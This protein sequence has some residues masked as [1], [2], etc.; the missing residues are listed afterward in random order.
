M[1]R[2]E[3]PILEIC[4]AID[5]IYTSSGI[6]TGDVE[7]PWGTTDVNTLEERYQT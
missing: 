7:V 5:V 6:T 1:K 2:Y 4:G 3:E